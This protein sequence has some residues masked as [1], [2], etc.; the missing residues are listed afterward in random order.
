LTG[1]GAPPDETLV[2]L[3]D[4]RDG[5]EQVRTAGELRREGLRVT[6][7]H[8]EARVL[9]VGM[10]EPDRPAEVAATDAKTAP[11]KRAGK[12]RTLKRPVPPSRRRAAAPARRRPTRISPPRRRA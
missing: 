11:T 10:A 9:T 12:P 1:P 8:Y 5:W 2:R 4:D 6:L 3:R 7:G